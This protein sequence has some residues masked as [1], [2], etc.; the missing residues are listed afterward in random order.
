M[1]SIE[2]LK[3][4]PA[5][6]TR[7]DVPMVWHPQP[8]SRAPVLVS[9]PHFGTACVPGVDSDHFHDPRECRIAGALRGLNFK[10]TTLIDR[11]G[12]NAVFA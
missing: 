1:T 9:I 12:K 10:G 3:P 4:T 7:H 6:S 2:E 8:H 11:A 5:A